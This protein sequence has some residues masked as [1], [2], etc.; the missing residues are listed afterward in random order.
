MALSYNVIFLLN[1]TLFVAISPATMTNHEKHSANTIDESA[2][3]VTS[4]FGQHGTHAMIE[5]GATRDERDLGA[6]G[7]KQEFK[8]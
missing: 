2:V 4:V 1:L 5:E 6:L 8:R 3:R 7:Y